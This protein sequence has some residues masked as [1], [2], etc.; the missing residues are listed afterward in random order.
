VLPFFYGTLQATTL[1]VNTNIA[2]QDESR[3]FLVPDQGVLK[4]NHPVQKPVSSF[5]TVTNNAR[6]R[7]LFLLA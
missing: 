2:G 7:Y 4:K 6:R 3:V 1:D 5:C